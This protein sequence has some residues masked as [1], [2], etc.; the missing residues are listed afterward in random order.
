MQSQGPSM[1]SKTD[2]VKTKERSKITK[3]FYRKG[4]DP[5]IFT[6]LNKI[7]IE[8]SNL[9]I[10]GKIGYIRQ[11]ISALNDKN[12]DP[13]VFLTILN[14]ILDNIKIPSKSPILAYGKTIT[15]IVE[16]ANLFNHFFASQCTPLENT[17]NLAPL[18]MKT[19]K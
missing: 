5:V 13:K 15:S 19:D 8:C 4:Q 16:K 18:L 12:T 2:Q 1:V 11:K 9:I 10:N 7:S 14:N 17:S 6:G 3:E